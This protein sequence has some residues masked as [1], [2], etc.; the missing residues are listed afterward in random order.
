[1]APATGGAVACKKAPMVY[2]MRAPLAV[3]RFSI[4][5]A[6]GGYVN[7]IENW[8]GYRRYVVGYTCGVCFIELFLHLIQMVTPGK[9]NSW[10]LARVIV[11]STAMS[12]SVVSSDCDGLMSKAWTL[13]LH[14][15][16]LGG[17]QVHYS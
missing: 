9:I 6:G 10:L 7:L 1:M 3:H 12:P 11:L 5:D 2:L 4:K 16:R 15:L 14:K 8:T 13:L 17:L